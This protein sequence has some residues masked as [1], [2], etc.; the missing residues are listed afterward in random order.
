MAGTVQSEGVE[1]LVREFVYECRGIINREQAETIA[2]KL[3]GDGGLLQ[4]ALY[5]LGR[6]DDAA[7]QDTCPAAGDWL[8]TRGVEGPLADA[9]VTTFT[10]RG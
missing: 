8:A 4:P 9:C 1:R 10:A 5:A 7:D 2:R 6:L 3:L